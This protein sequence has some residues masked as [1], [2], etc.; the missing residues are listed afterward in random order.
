MDIFGLIQIIEEPTR[1]ENTLD[2]IYTNETSIN[3]GTY[4]F[5]RSRFP[6]FIIIAKIPAAIYKTCRCP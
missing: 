4:H 5:A 1:E 3:M 6:R 2:S